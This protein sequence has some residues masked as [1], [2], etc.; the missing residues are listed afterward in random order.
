MK[1]S[2]G[3]HMPVYPAPVLIIGNYD[4]NGKSNIMTAAWGG[5]CCSIPPCINVSLQ[6]SRYSYKNILERKAFTVNIPSEEYVSE[7]DYFGMVS[8]REQDKFEVT[9]LTPIHGE[10]VNAPY[11]E[12]F[13]ISMEC[14][15]V[16][17]IELG[18]HVM[19]IGEIVN[20]LVSEGCLTDD[21]YPDPIK[22]KP[23]IFTPKFRHYYSLG[24]DLG[25][26]YVLGKKFFK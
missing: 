25:E 16:Q 23:I 11:V 26:A 19:L 21:D 1:K 18:S 14:R 22:V 20:T 4:E 3:I 17:T 6:K 7:S 2:I 9:N 8:G 13:P 5:I 24:K 10:K 12:E 15:L